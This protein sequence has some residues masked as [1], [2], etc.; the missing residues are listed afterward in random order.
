MS[1]PPSCQNGGLRKAAGF[2]EVGRVRSDDVGEERQ[3][4]DGDDDE[5]AGDGAVIGAE[6]GPELAQRMR[7]RRSRRDHRRSFEDFGCHR[8]CLMRGLMNP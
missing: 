7:R 5:E 3:H 2:G 6:I 8:V 4:Q 1:E